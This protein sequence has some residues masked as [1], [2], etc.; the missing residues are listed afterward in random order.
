MQGTLLVA[1]LDA[2]TSR[3]DVLYLFSQYGELRE[4]RDDPARPN[5]CLVEYYDTRHAG[6]P[7]APAARLPPRRPPPPGPDHLGSPA[8]A[9]ACAAGCGVSDACAVAVQ[10]R[11]QAGSAG[12]Q[13]SAC[14]L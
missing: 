8:S 5:C 13:P 3:Q 6:E 10:A 1:S 11:S 4:V 2:S 12:C 9:P 14:W 7:P